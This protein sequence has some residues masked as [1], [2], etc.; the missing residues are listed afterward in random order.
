MKKYVVLL[1]LFVTFTASAQ[2]T[3]SYWKVKKVLYNDESEDLASNMKG[4]PVMVQIGGSAYTGFSAYVNVGYFGNIIFTMTG[5]QTNDGHS[6]YAQPDMYGGFTTTDFQGK[7]S[8]FLLGV[9][10]C[11]LA[12]FDRLLIATPIDYQTFMD[13]SGKHLQQNPYLYQGDGSSDRKG[14]SNSNSSRYGY[15]DCTHCNG[16]GVCSTC[17]GK[18]YTDSPYTG[19]YM[20][21]P[22]CCQTCEKGGR[23]NWCQGSGK[24]YGIKR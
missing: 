8:Y 17:N 15:N 21:C 22:N 5:S 16:T 10:D 24:R 18:G 11:I 4:L 20:K 9:S 14:R 12:A 19:G 13:L 23:C 3:S 7:P 2:F 6:I 1:F